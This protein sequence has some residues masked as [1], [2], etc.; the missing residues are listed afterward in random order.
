M[1][2]CPFR[3]IVICVHIPRALPW[4]EFYSPFR[5]LVGVAIAQGVS[6]VTITTGVSGC[7]LAQGVSW[8]TITTPQ[9]LV[10]VAIAQGI[11]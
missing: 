3:A 8:V 2:F 10:G 6:R 5:A 9:A 7:C 1:F 4:A 11:S